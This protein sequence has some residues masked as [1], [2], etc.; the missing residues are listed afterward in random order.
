MKP[1]RPRTLFTVGHSTRP[2]DAF[3]GLLKAHGVAAL[4]DVR[5]YPRSRK[6]PYFNDEELAVSLPAVGVRYVPVKALGGR[7]R[8][9]ADSVNTGWTS[10]GFRGY[11]DYLQTPAFEAAIE[12]LVALASAAPTAIM[13]AEAVPWRCHRALIADAMLVRGW[14]VL[15]IMTE[16]SA[17]PHELTAFARVDG[18]RITYPASGGATASRKTRKA[19]HDRAA[20]AE[21]ASLFD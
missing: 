19:K 18:T 8:A 17:P 7:R 13:C 3:V 4:A 2:F 12:G 11:A 16:T 10:E 20:G 6:F 5:R 1:G 15:D 14:T 21:D 9:A